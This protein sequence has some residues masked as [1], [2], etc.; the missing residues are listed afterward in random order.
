MLE[1]IGR[2][3]SLVSKA[4]AVKALFQHQS[5]ANGDGDGDVTLQET[6]VVNR[7]L[8][9]T[10]N[11]EVFDDGEHQEGGKLTEGFAAFIREQEC[12]NRYI[13]KDFWNTLGDE[14]EGLRGLLEQQGE[15]DDAADNDDKAS[16]PIA[17]QSVN[18]PD[19]IFSACSTNGSRIY[20]KQPNYAQRSTLMQIYMRNVHPCF[21]V[22]H[23]PIIRLHLLRTTE[24][25]DE[26]H[27]HY[28]FPSLDA[29]SFAIYFAAVSSI[30]PE[31]C[32]DVLGE[33]KN[34]LLA[35][36]KS[37]TEMALGTADFLNSMEL[38]T[39]TAFVVY[40]VRRVFSMSFL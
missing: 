19:F 28:K 12:G 9:S 14:V 2:L 36:Y 40:L 17:A 10:K 3:E 26:S 4:D 6:E 5:R 29:L 38:V 7:A 34:L 16:S 23:E 39:L 21:P 37:A 27:A 1:R 8:E 32:M 33:E 15:V 25:L 24:L 31:E 11:S 20:F 18:S 35:R 13:S 30:P 22:L